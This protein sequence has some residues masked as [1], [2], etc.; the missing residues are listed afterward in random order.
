MEALKAEKSLLHEDLRILRFS[1]GL[2]MH[3]ETMAAIQR[4]IDNL[5]ARIRHLR[6]TPEQREMRN[7]RKNIKRKK[8]METKTAEDPSFSTMY[9]E[10]YRMR[11][12]TKKKTYTD[13]FLSD[14]DTFYTLSRTVRPRTMSRLSPEFLREFGWTSARGSK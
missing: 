2:E 11:K 13:P 7:E 14:I 4:K 1:G 9:N 10:V 3:K 6:E 12:N 5:N 8:F